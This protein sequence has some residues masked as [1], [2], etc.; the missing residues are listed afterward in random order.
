[1]G[2]EGLRA[3]NHNTEMLFMKRISLA[4]ILALLALV[5]STPVASQAFGNAI[6]VDGDEVFVGEAT[7]EMRSGVVYVF[8][9]DPS[10]NWIQ[11]Q[12][13]EPS[14]AEPG[15]RFGIGLAKY[16]NTL[17]VSATRADEGAGAVYVY[18]AQ[19]GTWIESGRLE[20]T[21][22]SP[23]DSLGTG[24][25][26]NND[27]I[28]VG[29][30]A[31][32]DRTGAAYAFR[33]EG[34]SWVQH[35]KIRPADIDEGD[36]FGS[37]IAL[38]GNQMLIS[39]PFGSDGEGRVYSF[40]YREDSD[41]WEE[42]GQLQAP[43]LSDQT[44]FGTDIA[45][46][47]GFSLVGAPGAGMGAVFVYGLSGDMWQ[48]AS[49]LYPYESTGG[50]MEFGGSIALDGNSALIGAFSAVQGQGRVFSYTF[51]P[52]TFE[53]NAAA[54]ISSD[55][56]GRAFFGRTVGLGG[57]IA[58]GVA[59]GA[60][61]GAG[62]AW[63]FERVDDDW[64]S[65]GRITGDVLGMDAI[66][67]DEVSCST[68]GEASGFDCES[69]DLVSFLPV[70][71]MGA[72]RG[73]V[74]NDVWGWTDPETGQEIVLVGMSNQTAFVDVTDP[75]M[76][77]YLGRLPMPESANASTWRDMKVYQNHMFVV[78]DGAGEHGMQVFDLTRL[79]GLDGSDPQ[80][81][82]S[83][84]HYDQ[85]ASAHNIVIN[86]ETGFAYSVGS[87]GGGQ[88]CGGGLHM[89]NIQDPVAPVFA[90][91]FQDMST[92]RQRTGYSHDAQCVIYHGPDA[93]YQGREI[94][95]GSNE[96][97]LSIA[98]VTDKS[99]PIAIAMA[100]YPNVGYS[101]QGWLSEDQS[102]FFMGDEL[103][104]SGG[105][106]TNTRTLIWDLA[107][108]DDPI[109]AREFMAET[110]ATDHNLYILGNTMYQSNYKSGLRVLDIS[111]PENPQLVGNFDTVPYGGDDAS[112]TGSWSNYPYFKSGVVVVTSSREGLFVVRYRPRTISE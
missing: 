12:R 74:T 101:H 72:D 89:I 55:E 1:M 37:R 110:K 42:M 63:V 13:I 44:M 9:R 28:M 90:G 104:E 91:C 88:T 92:G 41:T 58:V 27:W 10:G 23:A 61:R 64:T 100:S 53:W 26:M 93:D 111:D 16:E 18:Q 107:D 20:T 77:T 66:T 21:D 43:A 67:G 73:I 8:G 52:E 68:D 65:A 47:D 6:A 97:A 75:G 80:T 24:L 33:R 2:A 71:Q 3:L 32:D 46:G 86:E 76:P 109:L 112:M 94:C 17:L 11:T 5:P 62:A 7:Y 105:N 56:D 108:L 49:L 69:V 60:D 84:A 39:A 34:E 87:S 96:T 83:D 82:T 31:Q 15:D 4:S 35:S 45:I 51:N 19:G 99:N 57:N 103:D 78:S 40:T 30:I 102:Y 14:S 48:L 36:T 70:A 22:R 29:T 79:R 98:D 54:K 106:V 59:N 95:L 50:A 81:F 85:I 38:Q 25:A